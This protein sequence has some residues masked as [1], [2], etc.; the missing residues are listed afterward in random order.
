MY[1]LLSYIQLHHTPM[2]ASEVYG[3]HMN[4]SGDRPLSYFSLF[5]CTVLFV[6][7]PN[8]IG[9]VAATTMVDPIWTCI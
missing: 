1:P 2:L 9:A 6:L 3:A 5:F 7:Y 8:K 4:W